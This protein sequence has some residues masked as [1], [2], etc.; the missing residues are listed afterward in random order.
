MLFGIVYYNFCYIHCKDC[1]PKICI[2]TFDIEP[3][4]IHYL[5]KEELHQLDI[6]WGYFNPLYKTALNYF[7]KEI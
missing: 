2:S 5:T 1:T 7:P 4:A 6:E 3:P